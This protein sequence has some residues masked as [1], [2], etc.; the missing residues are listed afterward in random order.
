MNIPEKPTT[1]QLAA[2]AVADAVK[3]FADEDV[4]NRTLCKAAEKLLSARLL[5]ANYNRRPDITGEFAHITM[6]EAIRSLNVGKQT[7]KIIAER[8][9]T[10]IDE[11]AVKARG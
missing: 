6:V 9:T 3:G 4:A 8:L 10:A 7:Q 5:K 11:I 1:I 2:T